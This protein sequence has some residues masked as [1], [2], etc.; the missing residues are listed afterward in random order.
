MKI[1]SKCQE[2]K[3]N[4]QFNRKTGKYLQPYC[5]DCQKIYRREWYLANQQ[6]EIKR[7]R[8][9]KAARRD[10]AREWV[11]KYLLAHPCVDCGE[12]D[13]V[14][15]EFD[16]VTGDKQ[17]NI[18]NAVY[19]GRIISSLEKEITKCVVRCCNCHKRRTAKQFNHWYINK[20]P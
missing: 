16:H 10:K 17:F 11:W 4:D 9:Q 15:L 20:L 12:S 6:L 19:Q 18:G 14:V 5:R 13:P 2:T 3:S 8:E 1:C 7:N